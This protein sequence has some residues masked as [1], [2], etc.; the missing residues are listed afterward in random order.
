MSLLQSRNTAKNELQ[1]YQHDVGDN[2]VCNIIFGKNLY[3]R[4]KKVLGMYALNYVIN[5]KIFFKKM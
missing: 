4:H 1:E 3:C 5:R 2:I